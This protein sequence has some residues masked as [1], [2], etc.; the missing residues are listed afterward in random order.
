MCHILQANWQCFYIHLTHIVITLLPNV[1]FNNTRDDAISD[2]I[3]SQQ[4]RNFIFI[5]I[6]KTGSGKTLAFLLPLL[7]H[8]MDQDELKEGD[9]PI[10]LILAPTRELA[11]QIYTEAKKF[12]K[13][14]MRFFGIVQW[15]S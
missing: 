7:V 6:A 4:Y 11:M 13:V 1:F 9:G 3:R 12:A 10:G 15:K 2:Y 14:S 8:L 5:G